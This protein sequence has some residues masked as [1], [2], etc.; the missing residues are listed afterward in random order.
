MYKCRYLLS[1]KAE[2]QISEESKINCAKEKENGPLVGK[3]M[4]PVFGD[5]RDGMFINH[6]E[7]GMTIIKAPYISLQDKLKSTIRAKR[8]HLVK[9]RVLVAAKPHI[10]RFQL[11]P[12]AP[13]LVPNNTFFIQI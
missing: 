13:Y 5:P 10:I 8:S 7:N 6:L 1:D 12:H 11:L 9:K 2:V 4:G 3:T